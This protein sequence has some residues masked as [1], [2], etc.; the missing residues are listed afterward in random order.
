MISFSHDYVVTD[1]LAHW[2]GKEVF[3][4]DLGS[5]E[6]RG[7]SRE[8]RLRSVFSARVTNAHFLQG[9]SDDLDDALSGKINKTTF[10]VRQLKRLKE[11][12]YDPAIGFPDDMADIPPAERGSLQD[13][14]SEA[15]LNLIFETNTAMAR[16]Y[17]RVV[18]GNRPESLFLFPAWELVRLRIRETPR[19][20]KRVH[21]RIVDDPANAWTRRWQEAGES[22]NFAGALQSPMIAA[23]YSPIWQ[24]LGDGEGG[25][26]DSLGNPYPPFA[27]N[28]GMDWR[29]VPRA[30]CVA[31]GLI[32]PAEHSAPMRA[33]IAPDADEIEA[34]NQRLG[35][36]FMA[37]LR[38]EME[39]FLAR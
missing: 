13:L 11:L 6:L 20:K 38:R 28:S 34:L 29:A 22:V 17:G 39:E 2:R 21:S 30:E 9:M 10:R 7:F 31:L 36:E 5:A 27:F 15:R 32:T 33:Q 1:A 4:T 16:N 19:G 3:P 18:A 25:H 8:L 35:P 12:G 26:T 23:K 14:S 37:E 24:A